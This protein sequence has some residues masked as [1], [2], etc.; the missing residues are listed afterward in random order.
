M[1]GQLRSVLCL[2][3]TVTVLVKIIGPGFDHFYP[4]ISTLTITHKEP[5]RGF[6][7]KQR[8]CDFKQGYAK[9][10]TDDIFEIKEIKFLETPT[11][12]Y[13]RPTGV[14]KF[15]PWVVD[16]PENALRVSFVFEH[17]CSPFW[18]HTTR[19]FMIYERSS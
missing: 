3:I 13:S 18:R 10:W 5:F 6:L 17:N 1:K 19:E 11:R 16:I 15:G 2:I 7:E 8:N 14:Q 12:T 9:I 4:V